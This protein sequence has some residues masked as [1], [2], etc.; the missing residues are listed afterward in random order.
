MFTGARYACVLRMCA[1][2][3]RGAPNALVWTQVSRSG[4]EKEYFAELS[5]AWYWENDFQPFDRAELETFDPQGAAA[6]EAAW[7]P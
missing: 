4:T 3:W 7:T 1:L 5:E 2:A 6:V